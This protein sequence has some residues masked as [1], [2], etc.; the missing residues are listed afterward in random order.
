MELPIKRLGE[1]YSEGLDYLKKCNGDVVR[2]YTYGYCSHLAY[3][4]E[5]YCIKNNIDYRVCWVIDYDG[6]DKHFSAFYCNHVGI[7]IDN[8]WYDME[9]TDGLEMTA[10][11]IDELIK[12]YYGYRLHYVSKDIEEHEFLPDSFEKGNVFNSFEEIVDHVMEEK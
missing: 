9:Y 2:F 10:E 6:D 4:L 11:N 3:M 12:K 8:K 1:L 7:V 5:L